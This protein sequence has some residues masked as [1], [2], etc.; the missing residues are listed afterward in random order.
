MGDAG[1]RLVFLDS[2]RGFAALFVVAFH[3]Y[4]VPAIQ[5]PALPTWLSPAV[6]YGSSGVILFFVISAF[7]LSLTMPRHEANGGLTSYYLSR[8]FRIAPLFYFLMLFTFF[9]EPHY[10][11]A[12]KPATQYAATALFAFNLFPGWSV[13]TVWAGWTVGTEM[14]F[15]AVF[16]VIYL[17]AKGI[18][19]KL[20]V[21][22]VSYLLFLGLQVALGRSGMSDELV[23]DIH[24]H[25]IFQLLP[26][27][28]I[29]LI[30]LD[31][32]TLLKDSPNSRTVGRWLSV[33]AWVALFWLFYHPFWPRLFDVRFLEAFLWSC[34]LLGAAL[35]PWRVLVNRVTQFYGRIGYSVYLWHPP[36]IF[37][38]T[39][40][41]KVLYGHLSPIMAFVAGFLFT[42]AVI[43]PI[44][45]VTYRAVER[46]GEK[47]GKSIVAA[48]RARKELV[49]RSPEL[50]GPIHQAAP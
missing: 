31:V 7:S 42:L 10:I 18:S 38:S 44:A 3:S 12:P 8:L 45:Y 32:Y 21:L 23:S 15:Y 22:A 47:L 24:S 6:F 33:G 11:D 29:G 13:S 46:P 50:T 16:P 20:A 19:R 2:L 35:S 43:T 36:V 4:L 5:K 27:F 40:V 49:V 39:P 30:T 14:L 28:I 9:W 25:S 1:K 34:V 37:T 17:C 26:T 48:I 41:F